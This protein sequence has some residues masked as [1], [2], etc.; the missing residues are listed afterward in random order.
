MRDSASLALTLLLLLVVDEAPF[1]LLGGEADA[2]AVT[3]T[4]VAVPNADSSGALR[5]SAIIVVVAT[6]GGTTLMGK[7]PWSVLVHDNS[8]IASTLACPTAQV[9]HE[10]T[11]HSA[12][13]RRLICI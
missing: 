12:S 2:V 1:V 5:L 9:A 8:N 10:S 11:L 4:A 7:A 13:G 3:L 6:A